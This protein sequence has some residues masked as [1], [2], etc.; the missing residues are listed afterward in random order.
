MKKC[1]QLC[2][3]LKQI[4]ENVYCLVD[5]SLRLFLMLPIKVCAKLL[6]FVVKFL[7]SK[8]MLAMHSV[9][10]VVKQYFDKLLQIT[11]NY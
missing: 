7:V 11:F 3:A 4:Y 1:F 10:G 2:G 8:R 6:H 9:V 5:R